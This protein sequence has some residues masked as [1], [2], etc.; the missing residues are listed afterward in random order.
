MENLEPNE[1]SN[2]TLVAMTPEQAI[3]GLHYASSLLKDHNCP[4]ASR[5]L[6]TVADWIKAQQNKENSPA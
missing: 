1:E 3:A 4:F 2:Q 6:N 5:Y